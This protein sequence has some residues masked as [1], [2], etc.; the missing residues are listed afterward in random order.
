M[1]PDSTKSN[2]NDE[3]LG[4][5]FLRLDAEKLNVSS[6]LLSYD[7]VVY[8]GSGWGSVWRQPWRWMLT[9]KSVAPRAHSKIT[10]PCVMAYH[11][12]SSSSDTGKERSTKAECRGVHRGS[13]VL[14]YSFDIFVLRKKIPSLPVLLLWLERPLYGWR[15]P[16]WKG[17]LLSIFDLLFNPINVHRPNKP[18][19][20]EILRS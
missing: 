16:I 11:E 17:V 12:T 1:A 2:D 5:F 9:R 13:K 10:R 19:I 7:F 3:C 14:F 8:D 18:K 15:R 4:D 6:E 20:Y